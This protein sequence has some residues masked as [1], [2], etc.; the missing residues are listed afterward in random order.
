MELSGSIGTVTLRPG[1]TA[2]F[3]SQCATHSLLFLEL[4]VQ[5]YMFYSFLE[6]KKTIENI[7][8][9]ISFSVYFYL[10]SVSPSFAFSLISCFP[11]YL[12]S[13]RASILD[14]PISEI[15]IYHSKAV[16]KHSFKYVPYIQYMTF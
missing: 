8:F 16:W 5:V 6:G 4:Q 3:S 11:F 7:N 14:F 12:V 9:K 2:V 13:F 10:D 15:S 1:S